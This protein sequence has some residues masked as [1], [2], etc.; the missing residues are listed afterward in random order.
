M[1]GPAAIVPLLIASAVVTAGGQIYSG[2]AQSNQAQYEGKIADRNAHL[3]EDQARTAQE[4]TR[5][6]AQRRYRAQSQVQGAQ[7]AAMSANGI[8]AGF[9]SAET[10]QSDTAMIGSEDVSQI[11]QAGFQRTKGYDISAANYLSEASA[12]RKA[13]SN[14]LV[15]T[16]F[17]VASTALGAATQISK[18]PGGGGSNAYG[19]KGSD[20]IY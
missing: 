10:V 15:M 9:G 17:G 4:N 3:A 12:K 20:N 16:G 8:D 7:L 14:A 19:V 5:L 18:I 13:A 6:E 2:I 11:Y 1:C